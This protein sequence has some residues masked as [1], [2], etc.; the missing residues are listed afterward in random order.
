[1]EALI[2]QDEGKRGIKQILL[3]PGELLSCAKFISH[4][5]HVVIITGF[6]CMIDF[7]PP[8]E[9]DGPL[10]AIALAKTLLHLGKEVTVLTDE[11]NEEVLLACAAGANIQHFGGRLSLQSFPAKEDMDDMDWGFLEQV[12]EK[13]DLLIA[14]ERAG[15]NK[16]GSYLT[17]KGKDMSEIVSPL[18][19]LL[20][21][22]DV[23]EEDSDSGI[24][25]P[26]PNVMQMRSIGIG[27]GGNEVG[28][29][30]IY[31]RIIDSSIPNASEIACVVP[32]DLLLVSSVSNWGGYALCAAAVLYDVFLNAT[33]EEVEVDVVH[34]QLNYM[35]PT[36]EEEI[37]KCQRMIEAGARDGITG[38]KSLK[39]DGMPLQASLDLLQK[40]R[41]II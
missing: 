22:M 20:T 32:T 40:L 26:S 14:I 10:G 35:L 1:M 19:L 38:E 25:N 33:S 41:T 17:M 3:P 9:T 27:D 36:E 31:D 34:D 12:S 4:A 18:D 29:G 5:T 24:V 16:N 11:C 39:V 13:A 30:K 28:M 7:S 15:P 2:Q 8:T 23:S 37:I 6:P 21:G